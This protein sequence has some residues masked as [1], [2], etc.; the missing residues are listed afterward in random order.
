MLIYT[1]GSDTSMSGISTTSKS[2]MGSV[3]WDSGVEDN[4]RTVESLR[5]KEQ[6]KIQNARIKYNIIHK[7]VQQW[8]QTK[9]TDNEDERFKMNM[10]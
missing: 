1:G 10:E 3:H 4:E 6:D 2:T 5:Q 8:M 7:E 9:I